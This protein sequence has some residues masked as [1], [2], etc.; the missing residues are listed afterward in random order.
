MNLKE[1][2]ASSSPWCNQVYMAEAKA[3][4]TCWLVASAL[5]ALPHQ[6]GAVVSAPQN[7]HL[8]G[9]DE[10]FGDGLVEFITGSCKK[11]ESFL[12]VTVHPM[13]EARRKS[14]T[15]AEWDYAFYNETMTVVDRIKAAAAKA[16]GVSAVVV[17]SLTGLTE[18]LLCGL[19]GMPSPAK[20]GGG[21]DQSKWQDLG[22]QVMAVRNRL[23]V[24]GLHVFW[25]AHINVDKKQEGGQ[26]VTVETV[27][28][29]KGG[30][31]RHFG[32]NVDFIFR[33]RREMAK[34]DGTQVDKCYVDTKPR[35]G[36]F[37]TGRKA[38]LLGEKEVDLVELLK[39][40]GKKVHGAP[41]EA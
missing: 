14:G 30:E 8:L 35:M 26:E 21:M 28:A 15:T 16:G 36:T 39:K 3:G 6:K 19:A 7:L 12:N 11:P 17:S 41:L 23:V 9:F 22:R 27:N 25:E 4:K 32:A 18:G 31:A 10:A 5:G 24:S 29:G 20:R 40:L 38:A 2:G 37:A 34:Y 33:L 1:L 13:T